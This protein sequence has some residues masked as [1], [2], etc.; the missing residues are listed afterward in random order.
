[1]PHCGLNQDSW[2]DLT[3]L[4]D[5][6]DPSSCTSVGDLDDNWCVQNCGGTPA[7]CPAS[8]CK[9]KA[10]AGSVK[11]STKSETKTDTKTA[12]GTAPS[13]IKSVGK[14]PS[15]PEATAQAEPQ[16]QQQQ[17][18]AASNATEEQQ[19]AA[20]QQDEEVE[21]PVDDVP[22]EGVGLVHG[23]TAQDT[24]QVS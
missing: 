12:S 1:M 17:A 5:G 24:Q 15:A 19:Q 23:W 21:R 6:A 9:C 4:P 13:P 16:Q 3:G 10:P 8:L 7:N 14:A 2:Q 20:P 11:A 22:V 18:Q